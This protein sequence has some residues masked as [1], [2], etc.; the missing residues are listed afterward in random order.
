MCALPLAA[1]LGA[2]ALGARSASARAGWP[3]LVGA[4]AA[5]FG[6]ESAV[7]PT[8]AASPRF[9]CIILDPTTARHHGAPRDRMSERVPD[10]AST[11]DAAHAALLAACRLIT[12]RVEA[13][14]PHTTL[15]DLG[16]GAI[17]AAE[18]ERAIAL[19]RARLAVRD[20]L[21]THAGIGP[22][23]TL[24]QLAAH[25][26]V[27]ARAREHAMAPTALVTVEAAPTFLAA[28]P[29]AAL[30]DLHPRDA[31]AAETVQRLRS[32]G[33]ATLSQL[34]RL[35]EAALRAHF[36][37]ATG[38]LLFAAATGHDLR[39]LCPTPPA[40][41]LHFRLRLAT[42]LAPERLRD[43]LAPFAA[44]AA[45][46]LHTLALQA[47]TLRVRVC[48]ERGGEQ[49]LA[50]ILREPTANADLLARHLT[51]LLASL[52]PEAAG[53]SKA[54]PG[55]D[56]AC[57]LISDFSLT[58]GGL[59]PARPAQPALWRLRV[60]RIE[61]IATA[62]ETLAQRHGRPVFSSPR[63]A[64][65]DAI[66]HEDRYALTPFAAAGSDVSPAK[67]T[68]HPAHSQPAS[69]PDAWEQV[70]HRLHWW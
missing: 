25:A 17:T 9:A 18:A 41:R 3:S 24:A 37:E 69:Q 6:S 45:A 55:A 38:R 16:P 32:Y 11:A 13:L 1:S 53:A 33:I 43:G 57:N 65:P 68:P 51:R 12:P 46:H 31:I 50:H 23:L 62:A 49:I 21:R 40:R 44:R 66:F 5:A 39:P 70:P 8:G 35:A 2:P 67:R 27:A 14:P 22:S 59:A 54:A 4:Q 19:I 61:T 60:R 20:G 26:Q 58:L 52:L 47:R 64:I 10:A 56:N 29:I 63:L 7:E 36:G 30:L 48:W 42:P 34:V 15:L 28:L